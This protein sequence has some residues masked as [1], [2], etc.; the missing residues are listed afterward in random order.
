[1]LILRLFID[2]VKLV[3]REVMPAA[4]SPVLSEK[5]LFPHENGILIFFLP[6]WEEINGI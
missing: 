3:P 1:M 2:T 5:A 4:S 6:F